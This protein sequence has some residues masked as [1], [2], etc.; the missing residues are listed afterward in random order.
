MV[1]GI[2]FSKERAFVQRLDILSTIKYGKSTGARS[3]NQLGDDSNWNEEG[4]CFS[5][6]N[7]GKDGDEMDYLTLVQV[8][9]HY[10]LI[11]RRAPRCFLK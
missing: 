7:I 6:D 1:F 10:F 4:Q 11:V 5:E 3:L 2:V 9:Y 8:L